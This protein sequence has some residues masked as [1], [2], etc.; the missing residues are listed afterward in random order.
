MLAVNAED[1]FGPA[2]AKAAEGQL[3]VVRP[4]GRYLLLPAL[5]K[6]SVRAEMVASVERMLPSTTKRNV[7]V[8][9]DTSWAAGDAPSLQT[10]NA[11]IPFFGLLM[12]FTSI[13]H[14]VWIFDGTASVFELGCREADVLIVDSA[15]LTVLPPD[16]QGRSAK[17]MR[18]PQILVHDRA[19]FQL[20]KP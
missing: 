14:C 11:A 19:S 12:G 20:R 13:G 3:V 8:I 4:D 5:R 6:D 10:A 7:A 17:V 16:W 18:N 1:K 9:G 2:R 15:R